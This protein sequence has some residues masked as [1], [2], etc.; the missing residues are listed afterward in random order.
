MY[1]FLCTST[2]FLLVARLIKKGKKLGQTLVA[3]KIRY[4]EKASKFWK[5]LPI[6]SCYQVMSSIFFK[7]CGLLRIPE[8]YKDC[9]KKSFMSLSFS[10][11][12]GFNASWGAVVLTYHMITNDWPTAYMHDN[13][14][15]KHNKKRIKDI[16]WF[17]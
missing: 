6:F 10:I 4:S 12:W 2:I 7:S 11:Y 9:V 17:T 15:E 3:V 5:N 1:I 8:L 13:L 14:K 16:L